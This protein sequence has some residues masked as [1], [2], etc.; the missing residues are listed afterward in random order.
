MKFLRKVIIILLTIII[1][2]GGVIITHITPSISIR[3]HLFVTGHPIGDFKVSVHVNKGQYE[4]DKEI[5]DNENAMI[6]R[7]ADYNLYD[8]ATGNSIGNYKVG[9]SWILYFA[10]QYGEA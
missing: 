10:Q 9:K 3:T 8:G 5:L 1:F 6:Y 2:I 7:T 4:I